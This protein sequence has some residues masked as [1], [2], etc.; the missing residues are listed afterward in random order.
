MSA[1]AATGSLLSDRYELKSPIGRGGMGVVW[2][3]RDQL[4]E[5]DVAIKEVHLPA[6]LS[7]ADRDAMQQRVLREARAAA[8]LGHPAAVTV[9]DILQGRGTA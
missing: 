2:R 7:G 5:R 8:R 9:Y 4:L 6:E 3:A 1:D